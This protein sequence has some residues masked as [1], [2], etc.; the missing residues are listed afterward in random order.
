MDHGQLWETLAEMDKNL[1]AEIKMECLVKNINI[2]DGKIKSITYIKNGQEE[3]LEGDLFI[4]SMP[5]KDLIDG[6]RGD[7]IP[8]EIK[9]I[10]CG[11]PYRDFITVRSFSKKT[12]T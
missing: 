2:Q 10:G 5:I 7:N 12:K 11:L 4:S 8:E 9:K 3:E 1:G 6:L